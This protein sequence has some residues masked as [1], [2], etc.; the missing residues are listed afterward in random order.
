MQSLSTYSKGYGILMSV[1]IIEASLYCHMLELS[2]L[3]SYWI[4]WM[5]TWTVRASIRKPV[6]IQERHRNNRHDLYST[7]VSRKMPGTECGL[8]HDLYRPYKRIKD[9]QSGGLWKI[10]AKF[11]CAAKFIAMVRQFHD[12]MLARVQND[13]LHHFL[14]QIASSKAVY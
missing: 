6:W 8:L 14:W 1:T 7:T 5:N 11:G 3:G 4:D 2:L 13:F 9:S 12:G 10:I